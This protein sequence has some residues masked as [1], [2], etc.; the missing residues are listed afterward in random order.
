MKPIHQNPHFTITHLTIEQPLIHKEPEGDTFEQHILILTPEK[1]S[2]ESPVF[3]ILGGETTISEKRLAK[4]YKNYGSPPEVIFIYAEHRGYGKSI[5]QQQDQSI[6][7]YVNTRQ[8]LADF[9]QAI[10]HLKEKY[11]GI[12][13]AAG[14]SYAG[15]LVIDFA[16]RYSEDVKAILSSSGVVD[17]YFTMDAYDKGVRRIFGDALYQRTEKHIHNLTPEKL[18]DRNW[19]EREFLIAIIHGISQYKKYKPL[20]HLFK[21]LTFFSTKT[22]LKTLHILDRLFADNQAW[23]YAKANA[24]LKLTREESLTMDYQWRTWRFQQCNE[25]GVFEVSAEGKGI[26]PRT[27]EDFIAE[28]QALFGEEQ[29]RALKKRW[30]LKSIINR[31]EVPLVYVAGELDPWQAL[32]ARRNLRHKRYTYFFIPGAYHCPDSVN[33]KL[34]KRVLDVLLQYAKNR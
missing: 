28:C 5:S 4:L 16:R 23:K 2:N 15:G 14:Y 1:A 20:F 27:Q 26:F 19:L 24:K 8:A 17:W 29:P 32:G 6:P 34:G 25:T 3:F 21:Y 31:L 9:H 7:H 13:M 10:L 30:A 11:T 12:W 18:F 33:P 22:L